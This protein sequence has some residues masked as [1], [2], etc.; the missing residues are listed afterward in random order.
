M[1]NEQ[2]YI[3]KDGPMNRRHMNG[4]EVLSQEKKRTSK[5]GRASMGVRPSLGRIAAN[6]PRAPKAVDEGEK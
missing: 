4:N 1:F 6:V 5:S 2:I 3:G